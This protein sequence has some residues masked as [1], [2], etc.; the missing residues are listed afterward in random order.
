MKVRDVV[1]AV[2][3]SP[4][5]VI[6]LAPLI[7]LL[8]PKLVCQRLRAVRYLP[9][10]GI[11]YYSMLLTAG[12]LC[13]GL[14][15]WAIL[16]LA[17]AAVLGGGWLLPDPISFLTKPGNRRAAVRAVEWVESQGGS[18]AVYNVSVIGTEPSRR[19]VSVDIDSHSIPLA[20]RFLAV[21][22]DG[23]VVELG[24]DYLLKAYGVAF[25]L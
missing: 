21:S 8:L 3:W 17:G 16:L 7:T 25:R 15:W 23:S 19:I 4:F 24:F 1:W 18:R 10:L 5:L 20:R 9:L 14:R 6:A 11:C 22:D 2:L 13:F 12:V